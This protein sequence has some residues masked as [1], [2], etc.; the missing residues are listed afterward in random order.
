MKRFAFLLVILLGST[1]QTVQAQIKL[2]VFDPE[3]DTPGTKEVVF[4]P[5]TEARDFRHGSVLLITMND[6]A[7]KK[8]RGTL[9]RVD[10]KEHRLYVRTEPG[11]APIAIDEKDVKKV[12]K[13]TY[14][15]RPVGTSDDL[16]VQPE[17]SKIVVYNGNVMSISYVGSTL[18]PGEKAYLNGL[19]EAENQVMRLQ[20]VASVRNSV[21]ENEAIIQYER[22]KSSQIINNLL[23]R[24]LWNMGNYAHTDVNGIPQIPLGYGNPAYAGV[25]G[26]SSSSW[27]TLNISHDQQDLLKVTMPTAQ[28]ALELKTARENLA[29]MQARILY[30]EGN[31]TAVVLKE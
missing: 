4:K 18:S 9:V 14:A 27:N 13:A 6:K 26:V 16:V 11:A 20:T 5:A 7:A 31:I 23:L 8:V 29:N 10:R 21:L 19:E 22:R 25:L 12:E 2:P 1:A 15:I 17:I 3:K 24:Q 28:D 30:D